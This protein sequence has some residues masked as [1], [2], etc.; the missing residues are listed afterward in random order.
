MVM[1]IY[2]EKTTQVLDQIMCDI[3]GK[4]CTDDFYDNHENATLEANW[5]YSTS[6]DGDRFEIHLCE[7][8]FGETLGF[9]RHKRKSALGPFNYPYDNDPLNGY[10]HDI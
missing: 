7:N 6:R 9:L 3:C 4:N 8:C 2:K 1:R 5:G 10:R